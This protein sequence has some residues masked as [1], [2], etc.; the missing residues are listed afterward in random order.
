MRPW[1]GMRKRCPG[2]VNSMERDLRKPGQLL[3]ALSPIGLALA[4]LC[5]GAPVA[6]Q[7]TQEAGAIYTCIDANGRRLTSD[8]LIANCTDREQR[9]LNRD[10]SLRRVVPPTMTADERLAREAQARKTQAEQS[11]QREAVRADRNLMQRY[12]DAAA[13]GKVREAAIERTRTSLEASRRRIDELTAERKPIEDEAEFYKGKALPAKVKAQLDANDA[14]V[15][16]QRALIGAAEAE[17]VRV[18]AFYDTELAR[19]RKLW[20]GAEPGSLGQDSG[21]ARTA[22]ASGAAPAR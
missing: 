12:P 1:S 8:R 6:A 18:N 14:A 17:L 15:N 4:L 7:Q 13:H 2:T 11:A 10:G 3:Q 16:A 21:P 19:L 5:A 9:V 20:A 22:A